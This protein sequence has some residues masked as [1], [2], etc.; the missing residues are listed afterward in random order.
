MDFDR[1]LTDLTAWA[2]ADDRVI[3]L[4]LLGS[5]AE[6]SRADEWSDHDFFVVT[7]PGRQEE[8]RQEL[9]WLPDSD[10]V[11]GAARETAHGLKVL[12]RDGHVLEFAVFD[13]EELRACGVNHWALAYGDVEVAQ[14]T[15]A[16]VKRPD[17]VD[18]DREWTL[19]M[20]LLVIGV[21]RAR[22]GETLAAGQVIRSYATGCL[23][24]MLTA[25]A[26]DPSLDFFD[27]TRRL[28]HVL[29]DEAAAVAAALALA[30]E[31]AARGL[32]DV[33]LAAARRY[34]WDVD[35]TQA[36]IVSTRFGWGENRTH[37]HQ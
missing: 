26:A 21:G 3:G 2:E 10:S 14:A 28:E 27:P 37:T 19:F 18:L 33:A 9:T 34:G 13:L 7:C 1:F 4:V 30:P 5:T 25:S 22:R 17:P 11:A 16:A 23:L 6:R 15:K 36:D 29:P 31:E 8:L 24:R 35:A 20:S 32:T 12:Y